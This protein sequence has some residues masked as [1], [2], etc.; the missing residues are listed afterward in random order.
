MS[1]KCK[2]GLGPKRIRTLRFFRY[3][4]SA[5]PTGQPDSGSRFD[6]DDVL[7]FYIFTRLL[8]GTSVYKSD[9]RS[10]VYRAE[11]HCEAQEKSL[12]SSS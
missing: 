2:K 5:G 11:R 7:V 3:D 8:F 1:K 9:F 4:L 10:A 12:Y 6:G